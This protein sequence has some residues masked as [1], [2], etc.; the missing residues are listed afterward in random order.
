[1][2]CL[3]FS[4]KP[5]YSQTSKPSE[6]THEQLVAQAKK[7]AIYRAPIL[8][9]AGKPVDE[10]E[11]E[12]IATSDQHMADAEAARL[13]GD[14]ETAARL[15]DQALQVRLKILDG[16]NHRIV[17]ANG[18][19]TTAESRTTLSK[20]KREAVHQADLKMA[21]AKRF[22]DGGQYEESRV[23]A[24]EALT[25]Y[26]QN[27]KEGDIDIAAALF[28]IGTAD[29]DL[30]LFD[31]A[32]LNLTRSLSI[33]Q[34]AYGNAHPILGKVEDRLGWMCVLQAVGENFQGDKARN[35]LQHFNNAIRV[36]A[37]SSGENQELAESLD[38]RG[39]IQYYL[40]NTDEAL[41]DKIRALVIRET[42]LGPDARDTGVSY[43]NLGWLYS[44]LGRREL[45]I[46]FRTKALD[47]LKKNLDADHPFCLMETSNLARPCTPGQAGRGHQ[48]L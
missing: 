12:M 31:E 40:G 1:M 44:Q 46:P 25:I 18:L 11:A 32:D 27:L 39:T 29:V 24:T 33:Y 2:S 9:K 36:I 26:E 17:T 8:N 28:G 21:D 13:R 41:R 20:E 22:Y 5:A 6:M 38:N 16:K 45:V 15:A 48:A 14:F 4:T 7:D 10:K 3:L 19:K 34:T 37:R 35:A 47:I 30:G 43:S 23:A 42:I